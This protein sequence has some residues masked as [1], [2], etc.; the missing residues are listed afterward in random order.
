MPFPH[1]F[2]NG[3]LRVNSVEASQTTD[4]EN[5]MDREVEFNIG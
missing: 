3:Y 1:E 2:V 4:F 5:S